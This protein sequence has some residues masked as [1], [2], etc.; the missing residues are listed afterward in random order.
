M[1][2]DIRR[3]IAI[4]VGPSGNGSIG[5]IVL[6]S[7]LLVPIALLGP[8]T[9]L[10][11][12]AWL[13]LIV[14]IWLLWRPGEPAILLLVFGYQWLQASVGLYYGNVLGAEIGA[15][16][17]QGGQHNR[18]ILLT[19]IGLLVLA[20]TIRAAI[21]P[22]I[23]GVPERIREFILGYPLRSWA[24]VYLIAWLFS[25]TCEVLAP[26]N[27]GLYQPL[28]I[29][30]QV[31]WAAFFT[32]TV[33]TFAQNGQSKFYWTAAFLVEFG[34]AIGGFFST[35]A[36]VFFYSLLGLAASNV[37]FSLRSMIPLTVAAVTLV[38]TG[39][40]WSGIKN[41]YRGYIKQGGRE[42]VTLV[43]Y[44]EKMSEL[45]QLVSEI[46]SAKFG[47]STDIMINRIMYYEFFGIILDRVPAGQPH[48]GGEIWGN[49]LISPFMPRLLFPNKEVIDDTKLTEKYTGIHAEAWKVGVSISIGYMA[50]AYIDF[51]P[52]MMFAAIAALGL[53]MGALY[54]WLLSQ[55]G[56]KLALGAALAPMALMPARL[57]ETSSLKLLPAL[58]LSLLGC[59]VILK[60]LSPAIFQLLDRS[61]SR[62]SN[63]V[64][65]PRQ[66]TTPG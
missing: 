5:F 50:E 53:Y 40:V 62:K 30:S 54:R 12:F 60:F 35:F 3:G 6:A 31:K 20:V 52:V 25:Q 33:V 13:T 17:T 55:Q 66:I 36:D 38:F 47:E 29:L 24:L 63:V 41:E 15:W 32:L 16:S 46:D 59:W 61:R 7:L 42:Q 19:L 51:G 44:S 56:P 4:G 22:Q 9:A 11:F 21:G 57:L 34:L 28:L 1:A 45:G 18:A 39:I 49:G 23:R 65:R 26:I 27:Q 37:K 48:S 2:S 10:A 8:N 43:S 14:G 64:R 58:V